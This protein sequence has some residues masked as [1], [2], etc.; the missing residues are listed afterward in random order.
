MRQL[1]RS[2]VI[3]LVYMLGLMAVVVPFAL[4]NLR[5]PLLILAAM[6]WL[7]GSGFVVTKFED[8]VDGWGIICAAVPMMMLAY[9]LNDYLTTSGLTAVPVASVY[10]LPAH[11]AERAFE[12]TQATIQLDYRATFQSISRSKSGG[13]TRRNYMVAPLTT[14][15]WQ[16]ADPVLAWVGCSDTY[17]TVCAEWTRDY[18]VGVRVSEWDQAAFETA[19]ARAL[20]THDLQVAASAPVLLWVSSVEARADFLRNTLLLASIMAYCMW[21]VPK[22]I[23]TAWHGV[24]AL[25]R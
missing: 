13:T 6:I 10:E 22:I 15:Q 1:A 14:A 3:T 17:D 23:V 7:I 18:R 5:W 8:A 25:R 24:L 19:V 2:L 21:A 20:K 16:P 9:G 4:I 11:A 12:F